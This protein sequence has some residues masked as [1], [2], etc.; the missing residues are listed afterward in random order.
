MWH[1][2]LPTQNRRSTAA[3]P[4]MLPLR[5]AW[6]GGRDCRQPWR[7]VSWGASVIR[8]SAGCERRG[9]KVSP[10]SARPSPNPADPLRPRSGDRNSRHHYVHRPGLPQT[11]SKS[12]FFRS[13]LMAKPV[14]ISPGPH[15]P[16]TATPD[17][18]GRSIPQSSYASRSIPAFAS[19]L[20][21][22]IVVG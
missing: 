8:P 10:A 6:A 1:R 3:P 9:T 15:R 11:A 5:S 22:L 7:R 2:T 16:I 14:D 19:V 4:V 13:L 18:N 17:Q 21:L 12:A 20:K